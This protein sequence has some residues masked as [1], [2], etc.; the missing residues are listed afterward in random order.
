M[1]ALLLCLVLIHHVGS[2]SLFC[3]PSSCWLFVFVLFSFI[4]LALLC[5]VLLHCGCYFDCTFI[6]LSCRGFVLRPILRC[7]ERCWF[8]VV[9]FAGAEAEHTAARRGGVTGTALV[10][11]FKVRPS[12]SCCG[13]DALPL[14]VHLGAFF[15]LLSFFHLFSFSVS[16]SSLT[17]SFLFLFFFLS[18]LFPPSFFILPLPSCHLH[19][20]VLLP[21]PFLLPVFSVPSPP[22]PS[23]FFPSSCLLCFLLP[24]S[25]SFP[26][27]L[28]FSI[29]L[30]SFL[31]L[32]FFLSSQFPPHPRLLLSFLLLVFSVSSSFLSFCLSSLSSPFFATFFF[33]IFS[34]VFFLLPIRPD[35]TA[36][37]D[38]A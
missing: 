3:S 36:V 5:L 1:L 13:Q 21:S 16:S 9:W 22:P 32:F 4:M 27:L 12:R 6:L 37:V 8:S 35:I 23:P 24:S 26:F 15:L 20:P 31:L 33:F 28:V 7:I 25:L 17:P 18:S 10:P 38:W 19:F 14:P 2:A 29:F 11:D 30:S 34:L